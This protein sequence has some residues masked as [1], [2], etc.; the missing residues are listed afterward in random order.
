MKVA[1]LKKPAS[2]MLIGLALTIGLS[3]VDHVMANAPR[4]EEVVSQGIPAIGTVCIDRLTV[5]T[6]HA[7]WPDGREK[8][9]PPISKSAGQ[10]WIILQV[11]SP[12]AT[13]VHQG[14]PH[15]DVV[16]GGEESNIY[17]QLD[18]YRKDLQDSYNK[19]SQK[20]TVPVKGVPVTVEA[21]LEIIDKRMQE[22]EKRLQYISST[23]SNVDKVMLSAEAWGECKIR[24]FGQCLDGEGGWWEG[25]VDIYKVYVGTA[26]SIAAEQNQ[27]KQQVEQWLR[28]ASNSSDNNNVSSNSN[29][30]REEVRVK[31]QSAGLTISSCDPNTASQIVYSSASDYLCVNSVGPLTPGYSYFFNRQTGQVTDQR[32]W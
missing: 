6:G 29:Q 18:S 9:D 17:R 7:D 31:L 23:S 1:F 5:S 19:V 15:L 21:M 28:L 11:S 13:S 26:S 12:V 2:K 22:V 14:R 3:N 30:L 20:A 25:Y 4:C 8:V 16:Q 32:P 24:T 10:G 27:V